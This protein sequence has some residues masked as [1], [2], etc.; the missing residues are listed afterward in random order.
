MNDFKEMYSLTYRKNKPM[1]NIKLFYAVTYIIIVA[2]IVFMVFW[3]S[4]QDTKEE[5]VDGGIVTEMTLDTNDM[6]GGEALQD[7][8]KGWQIQPGITGVVSTGGVSAIVK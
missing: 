6:V 8:Y 4:M 2:C 5:S 1:N 3:V 7:T